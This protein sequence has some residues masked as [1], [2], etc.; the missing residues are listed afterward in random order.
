MGYGTKKTKIMELPTTKVKASRKSP[1]NMIIYG[2]PK[3][4]K[5]T[6]LSQLDNCLIIDLEAGSDMVDAL[7][8]KV[9]NLKELAD[10]G[11]EIIKQGRPYK[12]IAIDTIS[13]L[14]E[15]C[16]EE[17]KKIYMKTP[18]GKNF[19]TKNPGM[20]ILSLPNG[21]GYLY[22]RLAYKKW[23][24]R[25]NLLADHVILVA[26]LK[27]KMLEK[28]GKEVSVKD[29]DLTGKIKQIT[30]TNSDAIGY[31]YRDG[32]E[33]MISFDSLEE[34][35]AGTRCDHL[36]GATMPLAWDKIFID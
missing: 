12:Y 2:S 29:L 36:K 15:W 35:A 22:L 8:I 26:H 30:C 25:L 34:I 24:D 9:N 7:K 21:G 28:K 23:I 6:A 32:E 27:D 33:T 20:S 10:V 17:G 19:E 13:K 14:E 3:I 1:K 18:M 5:T 11:R 4:G 16:E 31:V